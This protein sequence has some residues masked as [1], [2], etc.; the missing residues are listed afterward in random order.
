MRCRMVTD[1]SVRWSEWISSTQF[2]P[3]NS[4]WARSSWDGLA[5]AACQNGVPC[6]ADETSRPG[7][8]FL[9]IRSGINCFDSSTLWRIYQVRKWEAGDARTIIIQTRA[10]LCLHAAGGEY[11]VDSSRFPSAHPDRA[12]RSTRC[13][14][15]I[16]SA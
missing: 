1:C 15:R 7:G 3:E 12:P 14:T 16:D 9:G 10:R 6:K 2:V 4:R 5:S 13:C 11:D 8:R